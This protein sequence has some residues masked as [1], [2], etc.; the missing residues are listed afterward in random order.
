VDIADERVVG[1][2][3]RTGVRSMIADFLHARLVVE[4]V[5]CEETSP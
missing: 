2:A 5:A 4:T 3:A 1:E